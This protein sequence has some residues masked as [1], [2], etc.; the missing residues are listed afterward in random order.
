MAI[1]CLPTWPLVLFG[2]IEPVLLVWAYITALSDPFTFFA[3]QAPNAPLS[4]KEFG[5]QAL[6]MTLQQANVLLL[7]GA[8]ATICS[9]TTRVSTTRWYLIAVAFADLGHIWATYKAVGPEYFWNLG[10]WNDMIWGNVGASVFLNINR[11]LTV[12]DAFGRLGRGVAVAR[13]KNA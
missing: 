12:M 13:K 11:W 3:S 9:F 10:E 5:P 1:S 6:A 7:L 2:I 8:I 4:A